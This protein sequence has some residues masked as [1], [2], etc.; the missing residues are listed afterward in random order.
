MQKI[1]SFADYFIICSGTS[2]RMLD[3]LAKNV[4]E[5]VKAQY[6][7]S[8]TVE[9]RSE[10]GWIVLDLGDIIVHIFLSEVRK[11]YQLEELWS[12]GKVIIKLQ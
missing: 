9:G 10:N 8:S 2:D 5:S 12:K 6:S 4:Q 3:A 11:Y 7:I 1:A